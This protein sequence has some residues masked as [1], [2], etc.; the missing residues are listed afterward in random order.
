MVII[1][2]SI[3]FTQKQI[4]IQPYFLFLQTYTWIYFCK[5]IHESSID[6]FF[7]ILMIAENTKLRYYPYTA[8]TIRILEKEEQAQLVTKLTET[9]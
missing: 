3:K 6:I 5:H 2:C 4:K 7:Q 9:I 8:I 1:L